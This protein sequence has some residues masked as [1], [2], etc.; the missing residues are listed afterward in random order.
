MAREQ[1]FVVRDKDQWRI[2]FSGNLYGFYPTA[3]AA[4]RVAI[5][6]AEKAV[7]AGLVAEV[8][9]EGEGGSFRRVWEAGTSPT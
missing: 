2:N 8:V 9:E 4:R 7:A 3:E 5:E 6:T 1:Y